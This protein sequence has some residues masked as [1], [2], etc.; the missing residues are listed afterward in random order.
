MCQV[1]LL[2]DSQEGLGDA[3]ED[4]SSQEDKYL[5]NAHERRLENI[6]WNFAHSSYNHIAEDLKKTTLMHALMGATFT[7]CALVELGLL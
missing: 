6:S 3:P 4:Q 5:S 7:A 1:S 2:S